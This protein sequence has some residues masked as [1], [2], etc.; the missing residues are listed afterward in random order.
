MFSPLIKDRMSN[1]FFAE[2]SGTYAVFWPNS[3]LCTAALST[4]HSQLSKENPTQL[5][6]NNNYVHQTKDFVEMK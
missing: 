4:S 3:P 2:K 6:R 5:A 1:G